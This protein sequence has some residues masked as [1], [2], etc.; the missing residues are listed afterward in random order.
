MGGT[1]TKR[2]Q[3]FPIR[4]AI[5]VDIS[6]V[7]VELLEL[8]R[9]TTGEITVHA[10][11]R[12]E[13]SP[14]IVRNGEILDPNRLQSVLNATFA[15]AQPR[16]FRTR[17]AIVALPETRVFLRAFEF[18]H[19][20][21]EEQVLRAVPFE[22]E[23]ALP[24]TLNE[25]TYDI[26]FHRSRVATHHVLFAAAPRQ[27]VDAYL[28]VLNGAGLRAIALDVE[29]AALARSIV[30]AR[31]D[32]VLVVDIGGRATVISVVEREMVHTTVTLPIAGD[33]FTERAA[34][35]LQL[36][37]DEA[38]MR[39][40]QEG[41]T[42]PDSTLREALAEALV[43]IIQ[44]I[45]RTLQYHETHTGRA[46]RELYLAGGSAQL[47]GIVEYLTQKVGLN[48]QVG[49]P[50]ATRAIR[51]PDAVPEPSRS[52]MTEAR[53]ALATVVGLALRGVS[54]DAATRGMNLLP[55][56]SREAYT[57]WR[58]RLATSA[59]ATCV[60]AVAFALALTL[61]IAATSKMLEARRTRADAERL[62]VELLGARFLKAAEETRKV[63]AELTA[64]RTFR[65]DAP[66]V[67]AVIAALRSAVPPGITLQQAEFKVPPEPTAGTTVKLVGLADRRET[68]LEFERRL[69]DFERLQTLDSPL[70][71]L[72]LRE[73]APF[74]VSLTLGRP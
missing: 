1:P 26:H 33:V 55:S 48:V 36:S 40:R 30:G 63:N 8:N 14:G 28:A 51:F 17:N 21:T 67:A 52:R 62:R 11:S 47:P 73:N 19:T 45:Q 69:R 5:G 20:L 41:M 22:A 4:Q 61:A 18:P 16:P 72:N 49:D 65:R 68:F 27:T 24:L 7:S 50:W 15:A 29:S 54:G 44:E 9:G 39:K 57:G 66:D 35:A 13:L 64:L 3:Y 34:Q 6:D 38:E 58:V 37:L 2:L 70:S 10:L 60:A 46:V 53:G 12:A 42:T 25:V 23:G 59:V 31:E 71:N 43:P 56:P 32:P 74:V